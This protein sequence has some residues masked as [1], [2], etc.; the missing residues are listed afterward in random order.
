MRGQ[1]AETG[2]VYVLIDPRNDQVRYVGATTQSL[3]VRL[4]GHHSRAARRVKAWLDELA[5]HGAEPRIVAIAEGV[6]IDDLLTAERAEITRRLVAGEPLLNEAA[7]ADARR[8]LEQ[9]RED[10]QLAAWRYAADQARAVLGGLLPPGNLPPVRLDV[11]ASAAYRAFQQAESALDTEVASREVMWELHSRRD[12]AQDKAEKGLWISS[13]KAWGPL[14]GLVDR[15]FDAVL[16]SRVRGAFNL[17]F[18]SS[19]E[20]A[21]YLAVLPWGMVAVSPWAAVARQAGM[22][23]DS[24]SF[25]NWVTDDPQAREALALLRRPRQRGPAPFSLLDSFDTMR[26]LSGGLIAL[27]AAHSPGFDLPRELHLEVGIFLEDALE[28]RLLTPAMATLLLRLKPNA[29]NH[30]LGPDIA[31]RIDSRLGLPAGTSRDVLS[32]AL[33]LT[34]HCG[35]LREL[36]RIVDRARGSLPTVETLNYQGWHGDT[37]PMFQTI[38]ASL[39]AAGVLSP[40][41]RGKTAA[42]LVS[43]AQG[44]WTA[45]PDRLERAA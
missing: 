9:Q 33:E 42:A 5:E 11:R 25:A 39:V 4:K 44:L 37:V 45:D 43:E 8:V 38:V 19:E 23:H 16:E 10:Q 31:A 12:N 28:D 14:R 15:H 29:L 30:C 40:A 18:A 26:R 6:A 34:P 24:E 27:T 13:R 7:T 36:A 17:G 3:S 2:T 20:I 1:P 21:Q 22:D 35:N 32:S 41:P